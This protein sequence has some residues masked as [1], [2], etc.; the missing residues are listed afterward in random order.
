[1]TSTYTPTQERLLDLLPTTEP[2]AL[3]YEDLADELGCSASTA[4]DHMGE[5]LR[6]PIGTDSVTAPIG[7]TGVAI[8]T[9]REY[10][11]RHLLSHP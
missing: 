5:L 9:Q 3:C 4:R 10:L 8:Q 7:S 1:M 2:N 11:S 6:S